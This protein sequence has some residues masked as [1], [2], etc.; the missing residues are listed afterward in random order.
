V[1]TSDVK[2]VVGQHPA[3]HGADFHY[4]LYKDA[5]ERAIHTAA[6]SAAHARGG[7]VTFDFHMYGRYEATY[8]ATPA[9]A[10]LVREI[11]SDQAGSRAWY[12]GELDRVIAILQDLEFPVVYRP[13]H[14]MSGDWFW[15]GAQVGPA[16]YQALW[17]LTV[18]HFRA[19]GVHNVLWAWSTNRT[20]SWEFYP[21][22]AY[23][24]VLGTDG[25]EPGSVPWFT[26]EDMVAT[27]GE[28]A[29]YAASHG[30]VAAFTETGHRNGYPAVESN[31][32]TH[33]VL[34]PILADPDARKIVWILAWINAPWSGPYVPFL[35]MQPAAAVD[36]FIEFHDHPATLF[37]DDL[38][39]MYR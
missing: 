16:D 14:E 15:W 19:R 30:K 28:L 29:A 39:D 25:Y 6:V 20:P 22:D 7:V 5:A 24:D 23:V 10:Q 21:G 9:N 8:A 1:D 4:F 37:E 33:R 13:L 35:G 3:V 12:L 2:D 27:L 11:V 26:V 36:D 17:R 32:W 34:E 31:F 18:E 38:P